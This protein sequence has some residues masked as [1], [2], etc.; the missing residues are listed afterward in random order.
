[1]DLQLL[2][3]I[4][5]YKDDNP[6]ISSVALKK[7]LGHQWYLS[8]ELVAFA[9]FDDAVTSETKVRMVDAL[10]TQRVEHPL[11]RAI[12]DPVL[13]QEQNQFLL[14]VVQHYRQKYPDRNKS[15]LMSD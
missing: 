4:D 3:D 6:A 7:F 10:K 1:I 14:L 8:E 12:V 5:K 13:I 9:F 2:K 11:K 15:T